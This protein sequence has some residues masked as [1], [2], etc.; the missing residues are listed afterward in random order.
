MEQESETLVEVKMTVE[1]EETLAELQ[2]MVEN[3]GTRGSDS[4]RA[5]GDGTVR[6]VTSSTMVEE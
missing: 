6:K 5:A 1:T 4:Y 2:L 3:G